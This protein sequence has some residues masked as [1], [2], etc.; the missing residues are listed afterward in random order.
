MTRRVAPTQPL[1][2][3]M[4]SSLQKELLNREEQI[5][6]LLRASGEAQQAYRQELSDE[7]HDSVIQPLV[8]AFQL[9][10]AI[11]AFA[12]NS[13]AVQSLALQA[14]ALLKET[15]QE[16]RLL[17][18]TLH[19]PEQGHYSLASLL[20]EDFQKVAQECGW[21]AEFLGE[22]DAPVPYGMEIPLRRIVHEALSNIQ[23]HAQASHVRLALAAK[24][25]DVIVEIKDRGVGFDVAQALN[26]HRVGG[27]SAMRDRA[28]R[29]GWQL[30]IVSHPGNGTA[31]TLR[32]PKESL[33]VS[34]GA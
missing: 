31:V 5:Q 11:Q 12:G 33:G 17:M 25:P 26:D 4:V 13:P 14:G 16:A 32:L 10:Q 6:L 23:K 27:L 15:V 18:A 9:L 24:G 8:A 3:Q 21:Q 2:R 20:Q 7:V 19:G 29:L 34:E 22:T 28:Q 1:L 30:S